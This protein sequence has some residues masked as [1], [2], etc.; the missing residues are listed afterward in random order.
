MKRARHF[1]SHLITQLPDPFRQFVYK[2]SYFPIAQLL[3]DPSLP[4]GKATVSLELAYKQTLTTANL[5][6]FQPGR[7]EIFEQQIL[8]VVLCLDRQHYLDS[9]TTLD[10]FT[11]V[12]RHSF[13]DYSF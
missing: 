6:R 10:S 9:I 13:R 5:D 11:I 8:I 3:I 12:E 7:F 1:R 4:P 2:Q